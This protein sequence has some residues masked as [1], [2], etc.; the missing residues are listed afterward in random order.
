MM[1]HIS[2][3][4][5]KLR[6]GDVVKCN[7]TIDSSGFRL[8]LPL[9][10]AASEQQQVDSS[11]SHSET[12]KQVEIS[13]GT[14]SNSNFLIN[15]GFSIVDDFHQMVD[16]Q[17]ILSLTLEETPSA[18]SATGAATTTTI[19]SLWEADGMGDCR[20]IQRNVTVAIGDPGPMQS[21]LSLCR[22]ASSEGSELS[23]MR[24]VFVQ[25]GETTTQT[26]DGLVP[27]LGAT[28]CRSPFSVANE[29]RAM[30]RLQSVAVDGLGGYDTTLA[31][32]DDLLHKGLNWKWR[33]FGKKRNVN[34]MHNALIVRRGEKQVMQHFYNLATIALR[35][36]RMGNADFDEYKGMLEAT[37]ENEE[38]M[39]EH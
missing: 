23:N 32:D 30:E 6:R 28:I 22:V 38:P 15:Y 3:A 10:D 19:E 8:V 4:Q 36:L 11:S 27:Q 14:H 13:Y 7:W 35:V 21:L 1:N 26:D 17:A 25:V 31:E 24:D 18:S 12:A 5:A 37:L 16:D 2:S 9:D 39:L 20:D 29:I 33:W 34:R